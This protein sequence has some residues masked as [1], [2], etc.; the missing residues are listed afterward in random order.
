MLNRNLK[1]VQSFTLKEVLLSYYGDSIC[2][3]V[4]LP[5]PG[6]WIRISD[7]GSELLGSGSCGSNDKLNVK[8]SIK[9]NYIYSIRTRSC[10]LAPI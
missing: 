4:K 1:E 9:S 10:R 6:A 3:Q 5:D 2:T 8:L 7:S